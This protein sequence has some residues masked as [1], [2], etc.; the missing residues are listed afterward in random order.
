MFSWKYLPV[1]S[2]YQSCLRLINYSDNL[3]KMKYFSTF[4]WSLSHDFTLLLLRFVILRIIIICT[5]TK[6]PDRLSCPCVGLT[7]NCTMLTV[8]VHPWF[9]SF[10]VSLLLFFSPFLE[11]PFNLFAVLLYGFLIINCLSQ[12]YPYHILCNCFNK[13]FYKLENS[14]SKHW[15]I[16]SNRKKVK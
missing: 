1:T 5:W 11:F 6:K 3:L 2:W 13:L 16:A 15:R 9:N 12:T 14:V 10:I 7:W 8:L 4:S